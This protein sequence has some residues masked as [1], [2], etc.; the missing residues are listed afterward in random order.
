MLCIKIDTPAIIYYGIVITYRTIIMEKLPFLND[1]KYDVVDDKAYKYVCD[2][3]I[4]LVEKY[5]TKKY[6]DF[7]EIYQFV[8]NGVEEYTYCYPREFNPK[9]LE[10]EYSNKQE[11]ESPILRH[12]KYP[13][14][15]TCYNYQKGEEVTNKN[16]FMRL[17]FPILQKLFQAFETTKLRYYPELML[18]DIKGVSTK[19]MFILLF[20]IKE[21]KIYIIDS[22][23]DMNLN[24]QYNNMFLEIFSK[25]PYTFVSSYENNIMKRAINYMNTEK[26]FPSYFKGYCVGYSILIA[27]LF[28]L[29][30]ELEPSSIL[31]K[32]V[33]LSDYDRNEIVIRYTNWLY[34][35][36]NNT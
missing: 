25:T 3:I 9:T 17:R 18:L 28:L 19:H 4:P 32:L 7:Q 5:L 27:E 30:P 36:V 22:N 10:Y 16:F 6:N 12:S 15:L 21:K 23:N 35:N 1:E 14:I 34:A 8:E 20:D 31:E 29:Y 2:N 24:H 11:L 26:N 33:S 13:R